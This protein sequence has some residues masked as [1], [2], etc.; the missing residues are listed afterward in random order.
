LIRF[1][2]RLK[3]KP[4]IYRRHKAA[5]TSVQTGK[6]TPLGIK[7]H[8]WHRDMKGEQWERG[9]MRKWGWRQYEHV[10]W[11]KTSVIP[12]LMHCFWLAY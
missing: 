9:K 10:S 7:S 5:A 1:G 11:P 12:Q 8:K 2:G 3:G 6:P 4:K